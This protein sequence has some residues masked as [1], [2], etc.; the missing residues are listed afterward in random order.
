MTH[1]QKVKMA[2]KMIGGRIGGTW[3]GQKLKIAIF[4]NSRWNERKLA[5]QAR[6]ENKRIKYA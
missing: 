1:K 6:T 4:N 5:I 2:R 3:N